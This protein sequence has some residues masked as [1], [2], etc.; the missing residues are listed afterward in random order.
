MATRTTTTTGGLPFVADRESLDHDGG[1]TID[2]AA[3]PDSFKD[4]TG[5]KF[6][7]AGY[8]MQDPGTVG[9]SMVPANTAAANVLL[10]TNAHEALGTD[11]LTGYGVIRGGVIYSNLLPV[12]LAG[13]AVTNLKAA[14]TGF[15]FLTYGDSTAA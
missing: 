6:I 1:H 9:G 14:G 11:A 5:F 7:P 4:A 2:W 10:L 3:V 12:A 8:P 15:V 13:A